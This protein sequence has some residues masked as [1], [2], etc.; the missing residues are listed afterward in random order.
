NSKD[1]I[2]NVPV[3][4]ATGFQFFRQN[5]GEITN[6]GVE[7]MIGGTPIKTDNFEWSVSANIAG[8]KNKLVSLIDGQDFFQFTTSNDK[9]VDVRAQVGDGF[10]DI[11]GTDWLR[12]D[13]GKLLLTATGRPQATAERVKLG[14][15]Q[16]D[17]TGG[18]TNTFNYKNFSLNFLIDFR[19]GGQIYSGTDAALDAGGVST[20]SLEYRDGI[21]L[22]GVWDDN[23]TLKPNT[24]GITGQQY[25]GAASGI[26]SEYVY[27]QTNARLREVSLTYKLSSK[28]LK[29]TFVNS[30]SVSLTGRN[31][32]FLFRDSENVD[33]ESSYSTS[34]FAQG[35]LY[36]NLPTTSSVGLSLNI[37]F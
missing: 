22:D 3:D 37:K 23:G 18:L 20:R 5:V 13:D 8:N 10:G 9:V 31:L 35:V 14:N 26:A 11:Y 30:A 36:Y 29:N 24:T 27:D 12:T 28:A 32:F 17:F 4:P 6:K 25:W 34:N 16:P 2:F 19:I 7:F 1:L 15:Y 21:T 33:P